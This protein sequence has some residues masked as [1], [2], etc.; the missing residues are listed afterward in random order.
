VRVRR[1]W[2]VADRRSRSPSRSRSASIRAR[3][4]RA[5]RRPFSHC[6]DHAQ[7]YS[8]P[9][10]SRARIL[11]TSFIADGRR[12]VASVRDKQGGTEH[13]RLTRIANQHSR[14]AVFDH[15]RA[16]WSEGRNVREI[17]RQTGFDR[18]TITKWIRANTLPERSASAPKTTSPRHFEDYLS[19]RWSEGLRAQPSPFP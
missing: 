6:E 4:R 2:R 15:F 17:V 12:E 1:G 5:N 9:T 14:Q 3:R 7:G 16:L 19:R 11:R 8:G 13:R 18:R 10:Q